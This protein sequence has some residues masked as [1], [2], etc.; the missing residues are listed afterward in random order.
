M[1]NVQLYI[2][3]VRTSETHKTGTRG[4]LAYDNNTRAVLATLNT[5][6][7]ET[8]FGKIISTL[9]IP[10]LS[11]STFK[12]REREI[13]KAVEKKGCHEATQHERKMAI[14]IGDSD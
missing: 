7:G 14:E 9:K 10:P 13:G 3:N 12:R 2:N 6:I 11:R 5:G 1:I 4:P 8:H